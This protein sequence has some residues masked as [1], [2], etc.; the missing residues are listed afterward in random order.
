MGIK[1]NHICYV[2]SACNWVNRAIDQD[3]Q[4]SYFLR[5]NLIGQAEIIGVI[6]SNMITFGIFGWL[7][8]ILQKMEKMD[9]M[10]E[11]NKK[12]SRE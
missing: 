4:W 6:I 5:L 12:K 3:D 10:L 8:F 7:I 11:W 9:W 2:C 1:N